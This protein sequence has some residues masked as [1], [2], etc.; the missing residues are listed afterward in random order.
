MVKKTNGK[1]NKT[2]QYCFSL[3][4]GRRKVCLSDTFGFSS[5]ILSIHLYKSIHYVTAFNCIQVVLKYMSLKSN[6]FQ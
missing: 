6:K 3:L 5:L 4:G 1:G 2:N